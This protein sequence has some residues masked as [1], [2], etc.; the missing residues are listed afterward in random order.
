MKKK[1]LQTPEEQ[2]QSEFNMSVADMA[3]MDSI[4][5]EINTAIHIS[6]KFRWKLYLTDILAGLRIFYETMRP[7]ATTKMKEKFDA[8]F[9]RHNNDIY[10]KGMFTREKYEELLILYRELMEI[11]QRLGFGV[12]VT[13][14]RDWTDEYA[15]D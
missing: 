6:S 5:K 13:T 12:R 7:V 1:P 9:D 15:V 8:E 11:R 2:L 14:D 10:V 3:R 4:L